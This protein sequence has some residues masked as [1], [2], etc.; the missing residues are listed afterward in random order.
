MFLKLVKINRLKLFY[1]RRDFKFIFSSATKLSFT[2][3]KIKIIF[4]P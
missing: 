3:Q 2:A 4:E 1:K